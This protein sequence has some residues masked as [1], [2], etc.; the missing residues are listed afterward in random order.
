M[1]V[2]SLGANRRHGLPPSS[3]DKRYAVERAL[4]DEICSQ[5]SDRRIALEIGV[6]STMVSNMRTLK[7]VP[8]ADPPATPPVATV[9]TPAQASPPVAVSTFDSP[10]AQTSVA[11][12]IPAPAPGPATVI[13]PPRQF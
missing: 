1:F 9:A 13:T 10:A 11:T 12:P 6:S 5:W 4:A 3:A 7:V 8:K 2:F